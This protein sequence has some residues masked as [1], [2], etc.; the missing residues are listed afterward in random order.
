[1]VRLDGPITD[2][3]VANDDD[4]RRPGPLAQ[5]DLHL[6]QGRRRDHGLRHRPRRPHHL[7][8]Q[9]PRRL[10][11]RLGRPD[12]RRSPCP[13]PRSSR[14][15]DE[16]HGAADRHRRRARRRRRGRA[17]RPG[18]RRR[19][20]PRWSAA[21]K[22]GD[23]AAGQPAGHASPRSAARWSRDDRRQPA[24]RDSTGGFMF[25][26]GQGSRRHD[27]RHASSGTIDPATGNCRS[28]RHRLQFNSVAAGTTL[29][30]AG[31]SPRARPARR[32]RT[33]P[34]HDGLVTHAGRAEPDRAFGRDRELP[35]RRRVP[36]PDLAAAA[37][38]SR[39]STS[40]MASA[41]PSRRPCSTDGR[42]SMR[43]RPEVSELS[44][45]GRGPAQRLQRPGADHAPRRDD[46]RARLRPELHDRRPAAATTTTT[47]IDE[48]PFLGNLPILGALFRSTS[49]QRDETELVIVV[50]P[51]LV[52][53]V[54]AQRDRAAD[55]R[56]PQRRRGAA[57]C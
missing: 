15:A 14:D 39:S 10:E 3:F 8:G 25:G 18:L 54:S 9:C 27:H 48:A 16:R 45:A 28:A 23:S 56:L 12:A 13:R 35:R 47:S 2:I 40:N 46:G 26:I 7:F 33:S 11:S 17:P 36:D 34:R 57:R 22:H 5:P 50:T 30:V 24:R 32:A 43:V 6:R 44:S 19:Q 49:F 53:P 41:W 38:R 31:T 42:I 29:G 4:R 1:M 21:C 51:Y 20:A 55:R 52:R 37:A